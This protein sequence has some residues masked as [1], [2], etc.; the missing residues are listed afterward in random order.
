MC[1]SGQQTTPPTRQSMACGAAP[2]G[3]DGHISTLWRR[4]PAK[5]TGKETAALG[6]WGYPDWRG[7]PGGRL[8]RGLAL[9]EGRAISIKPEMSLK[10]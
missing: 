7:S 1:L 5:S 4:S 10:L 3:E 9:G 8:G 2:G 6:G